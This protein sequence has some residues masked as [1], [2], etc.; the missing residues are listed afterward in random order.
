MEKIIASRH[1]DVD[2]TIKSYIVD[3]LTKLEGEYGKLTSVRV[4]LE[5]QKTWYFSEVVLRGKHVDIE[6]KAQAHDLRAAIDDAIA[7]TEVQ[8]RK[9][10]DRVHD[11][12]KTPI[13][14]VELSQS[15][16]VTDEA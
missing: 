11:H 2:E 3:Q 1:F 5:M 8:L 9:H 6:A 16:L 13:S 7:K 4:V 12:A 14:E 15:D 10:L